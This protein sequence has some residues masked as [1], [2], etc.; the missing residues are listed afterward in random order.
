MIFL[1]DILVSLS[2]WVTSVTVYPTSKKA[3]KNA[4][5]PLSEWPLL[6]SFIRW[7]TYPTN[8]IFDVSFAVYH[9]VWYDSSLH[10]NVPDCLHTE[11]NSWQGRFLTQLSR[12]LTWISAVAGDA[13]RAIVVMS[14]PKMCLYTEGLLSVKL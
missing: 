14:C 6:N 7:N 2:H 12:N 1:C 13:V 10:V 11:R 9:Y 4:E 5:E 8:F 3:K